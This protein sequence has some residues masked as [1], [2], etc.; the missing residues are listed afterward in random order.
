MY[1]TTVPRGTTSH[2]LSQWFFFKKKNSV[3]YYRCVCLFHIKRHVFLK[4]RFFLPLLLHLV[5]QPK[6]NTGSMH[7]PVQSQDGLLPLI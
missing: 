3:Y 7:F 6:Q 5:I 2:L 4:L 1:Q